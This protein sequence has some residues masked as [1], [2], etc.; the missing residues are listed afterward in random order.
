M[1]QEE[2][3]LSI[4]EL[5]SRCCKNVI[6]GGQIPVS[7]SANVQQARQNVYAGKLKHL[8]QP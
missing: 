6:S 4:S 5:L 8:Q 1:S 7:E 3:A 2:D